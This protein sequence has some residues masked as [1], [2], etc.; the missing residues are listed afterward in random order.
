MT[1]RSGIV[2]VAV[3]GL[4]NP[5]HAMALGSFVRGLQRF[6]RQVM[7]VQVEG[8]WALSSAVEPL[9]GYQVDAV[10]TS[11]SVNEPDVAQ[12]LAHF[13]MPIVTMNP[14]GAQSRVRCARPCDGG[15]RRAER[16]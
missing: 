8:E 15:P 16:A 5:F 12:V 3:G 7:L 4:S 14:A 6:R 1:G 2:A 13:G 9:A 10:L 11:L